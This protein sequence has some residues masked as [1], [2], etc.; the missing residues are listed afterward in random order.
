MSRALLARDLPEEHVGYVVDG[1]IRTSLRGIDTH[2]VT[3]FPTYL[4][5]LDGGR[6]RPVPQIK[7][8]AGAGA[9]IRVM[10]A[11]G[12]LGLVAGRIAVEEVVDLAERFGL[13]AVLVHNSNHF[14]AA[15][16]YTLEIA[17]RGQVGL[18][19]S[20][21]DALVAPWNGVDPIFGTNPLSVAA[22]ATGDDV[23]CADLATSQTSYSRVKRFQEQGED[24]EERWALDETGRDLAVSPQASAFHALQP[25]GSHKG[26]CLSMLVEIL[27][28]VLAGG[29]PDHEL[30][31]LYTEPF[32]RPREISHL[33]LSID[34]A[35]VTEPADFRSR[36]TGLLSTV[37]RQPARGRTPVIAPGDLEAATEVQRTEQGIP[38]T[39]DEHEWFMRLEAHT[40]SPT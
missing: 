6:A 40:A 33:L 13:G 38:L 34:V 11:D 21:S 2:G 14:G 24:I 22:R 29:P 32:D 25:L 1:L 7:W 20:N 3:L 15:S 36:L 28:A 19:L 12:A 27:T 31:H 10:D 39:D 9:A 5:E 30:S 4:A 35:A 17:G 23:F 18:C 16:I 8:R 37:R 26:Q